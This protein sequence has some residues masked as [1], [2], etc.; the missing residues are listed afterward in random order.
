MVA[1][2][3]S[4]K[5]AESRDDNSSKSNS[6]EKEFVGTWEDITVMD[7][8]DNLTGA[9]E[10]EQY[11]IM[12]TLA[13]DDITADH[14]RQWK[15]ENREQMELM[16]PSSKYSEYGI[17]KRIVLA[18]TGKYKKKVKRSRRSKIS[19]NVNKGR[20]KDQESRDSSIVTQDYKINSERVSRPQEVQSPQ[21]PKRLSRPGEG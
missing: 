7:E 12:H 21:V 19:N 14:V 1:L 18:M 6:R 9:I 17:M 2:I 10:R 11:R 3:R 13:E 4:Q 16:V 15:K 8:L 5:N 20:N